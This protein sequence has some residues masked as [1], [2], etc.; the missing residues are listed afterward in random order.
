VTAL[1]DQPRSRDALVITALGD[2]KPKGS[3]RHVGKGR[4]V[5]QVAGSKPWRE[6]VKYAALVYLHGDEKPLR[7]ETFPTWI[8]LDGPICCEITYTVR[9]PT[10]APKTRI[11]WPI[12]RSSGDVDKVAR[13]C[14]DA[15]VDAGV[16]GDD[17]QVVELTVR[18]VYPDEGI[19][20]LHTPGAVIRVWRLPA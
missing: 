1:A 3:M 6:A 19:D 14:L 16:M 7:N 20:A 5:E 13:N 12:T 2:P 10:S 4:M 8:P 17:S 11:S 9:K 18:K 15:L